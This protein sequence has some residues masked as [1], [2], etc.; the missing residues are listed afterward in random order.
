MLPSDETLHSFSLKSS[1]RFQVI[2]RSMTDR[3]QIIVVRFVSHSQIDKLYIKHFTLGK[4]PP[5]VYRGSIVVHPNSRHIDRWKMLSDR[6]TV[7]KCSYDL[8]SRMNIYRNKLRV[9]ARRSRSASRSNVMQ[10]EQKNKN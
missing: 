4:I 7:T 3:P 10:C 1:I 9:L 2:H 6:P 8:Q 5:T